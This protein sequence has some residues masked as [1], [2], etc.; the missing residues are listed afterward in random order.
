MSERSLCSPETVRLRAHHLLCLLTFVGKGY[1]PAF[2]AH[3]ERVV[4]R[5]NAGAEAVLVEGP[6]DI[7]AP[8]LEGGHHCLKPRIAARDTEA[9]AAVE[10]ALGTRIGVGARLLLDR[11]R[12]ARLREAFADGSIRAACVRCQWSQLCTEVAANGY[13]GVR[14]IGN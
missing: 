4:A 9:L 2:V 3:Y 6:D 7:C 1:T 14:L 10:A 11:E 12:V 5:L 8:M 13:A